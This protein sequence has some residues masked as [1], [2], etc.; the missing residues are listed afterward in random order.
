MSP[1][2]QGA[3]RI[4]AL[5]FIV[6]FGVVSALGDVV[7]ETARSMI[8]PF[9]AHFG[10]TAFVVG[11]VTGIGE[12]VALVLR[13]FSGR[14]TDRTQRPWPQTILGYALTMVCVPLIALSSGLAMA[15]ALYN[16][17]R[18]GKA[19]RA[20]SRDVMLAHASA[21]LGRGYAFGLHEALDQC[22]AL[23]G[24]LAI[25]G[26]FAL[27]GTYRQAFAVLA[28][29]SVIALVMLGRLRRDVP[30]P[31]A[32]DPGSRRSTTRVSVEGSLPRQFWLYA[33]FTAST[34]LGFATWAVLAFH[35]AVRHVLSPSLIAVLYAGAMGAAAIAALVFGRIYDRV[36]LRGLVVLP[37][38]A[39]AVPWLS[40]RGSVATVTV[41]ALLWGVAMGVHESTMRAAVTDLV[42]AHRRGAGYG[43]FTAIYGLAWLAGAALIGLLYEH[44]VSDVGVFVLAVQALAVV[45]LV[46]LLRRP[47]GMIEA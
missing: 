16:G 25:A 45:L 29:P 39:A 11:V 19:V 43:T 14:I 30:D 17:E 7:Y 2:A 8:G 26:F 41:G 38:L 32:Y 12:A 44:G 36:G 37:P 35:L 31:A 10:A 47:P 9:L 22:G 18:F 27:G 4:T 1:P 15:A 24:P 46:P 33:M 6:G 3:N 5:R 23:L 13:L 21:Q 20:P 28:L 42:P 34:M 40:F